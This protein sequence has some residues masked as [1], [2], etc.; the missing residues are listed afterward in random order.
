MVHTGDRAARQAADSTA[1]RLLGRVGMVTYGVVHLLIA[2]LIV[3]VAAGNG[4]KAD[5]TGA[6]HEVASTAA[7][8]WPLWIV[9]V[10]LA[11]LVVQQLVE[12]LLARHR[13]SGARLAR[14]VGLNL[15][16]ALLFGYL[17]YSAGRTAAG[18]KGPSDADQSGLVARVLAQPYGKW[19]VVL[20]GLGVLAGAALFVHRG[21]TAA[22]RRD[23]DLTSVP[24][25]TERTAVRLGRVGYCALGGVY[26]V[27]GALVVVAALRADPAKATGLDASLK[28]LA[29]QPYGPYLLYLVAAGLAAFGVF[30]LFDARYRRD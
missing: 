12:A 20:A 21:V 28:A 30:A 1:V 2:Y 5:K 10:G 26:A 13:H 25:S 7:G 17:S 6:L 27:A 24:A 16:E 22:F 23:L 9:C 11:A 3:R 4:G 14:A 29:A 19:I 8:K 18:G 15:V